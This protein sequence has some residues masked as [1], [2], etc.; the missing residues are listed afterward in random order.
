MRVVRVDHH[1]TG[2]EQR[3][4]GCGRL[5]ATL[6][7]DGYSAHEGVGRVNGLPQERQQFDVALEVFDAHVDELMVNFDP[8]DVNTACDASR[9]IDDLECRITETIRDMANY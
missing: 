8:V 7:R 6:D 2:H 4:T 5:G 3:L 9:R 1:P